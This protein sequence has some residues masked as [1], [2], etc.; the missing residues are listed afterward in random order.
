MRHVRVPVTEREKEDGG[1]EWAN[2][3]WQLLKRVSG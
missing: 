1:R 2:A 3:L